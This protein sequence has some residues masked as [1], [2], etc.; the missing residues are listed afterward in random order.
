MGDSEKQ[1]AP[2]S[3]KLRKAR[4]KGDVLKSRYLS[5][6]AALLGGLSALALL[7]LPTRWLRAIS[8]RIFSPGQDLSIEIMLEYA[9]EMGHVG[10]V[11]FLFFQ[12]VVLLFVLCVE[13]PQVGLLWS[14]ITFNLSRIGFFEGLRRIFGC[15]EHGEGFPKTILLRMLQRG[16]VL[17]GALTIVIV[18][19]SGFAEVL[20]A[21]SIEY[22]LQ[23]VSVILRDAL[24]RFGGALVFGLTV[25]GVGDLLV[26]RQRRQK[27]L[28][29]DR[30]EMRQELRE[31]EGDAEIK[32]FRKQLHQELILRDLIEGVR[33]AKVLVV[34]N[35]RERKN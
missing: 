11:F 18:V 6:A 16:L 24:L 22:D 28:M 5:N 31:S 1:F 33:Q 8:Q 17:A 3:R 10:I 32:G 21:D 13:F 12:G 35:V 23:V 29:M 26:A 2:S 34:G 9:C 19:W 4:E 27:R 15:S 7:G 14:P 20:F 25:L 30:H